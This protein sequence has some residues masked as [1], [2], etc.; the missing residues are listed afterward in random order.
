MDKSLFAKQNDAKLW[1]FRVK[2]NNT[3]KIGLEISTSRNEN[4]W[5]LF[6]TNHIKKQ[7]IV[8]TDGWPYYGFLDN[9]NSNYNHGT[10][11]H[12]PEGNFGFGSHSTII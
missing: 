11:V 5:K 2:N 8:I 10:H 7:N 4:N 9:P 12:S 6:I 1:V 3:L